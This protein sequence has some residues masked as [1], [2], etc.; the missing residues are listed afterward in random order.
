M[1]PNLRD[2]L[3]QF[4]LREVKL[5][6]HKVARPFQVNALALVELSDG[7]E[8][9]PVLRSLL[10]ARNIAMKWEERRREADRKAARAKGK[11]SVS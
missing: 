11:P 5:T 1:F 2:T 10:H 9:I 8:M 6:L 4:D 3:A 7:D